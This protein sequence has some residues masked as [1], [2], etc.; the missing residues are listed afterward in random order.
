MT[1]SYRMDKRGI[2]QHVLC[3]PWMM[4][5]MVRRAERVKAF[6]EAHAPFDPDDRDGTHY[7]DSFHVEGRI[8]DAVGDYGPTKRAAGTVSNTDMP[9]A[10]F[11]EYGRP[12]GVDKNGNAYP[13]QEEH[14]TLGNAL[15]AAKD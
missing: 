8:K 12:A 6:A 10:L 15:E 14:R 11:V 4:A 13:K 5:E 9:T 3:A 1:A 7:R 2:E